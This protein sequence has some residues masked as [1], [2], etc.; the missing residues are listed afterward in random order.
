MRI[1]DLEN[2]YRLGYNLFSLEAAGVSPCPCT[3]ETPD[4]GYIGCNSHPAATARVG[5]WRFI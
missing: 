4:T 2:H 1:F 5:G 3:T